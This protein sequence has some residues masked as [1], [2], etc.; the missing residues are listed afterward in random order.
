MLQSVTFQNHGFPSDGILFVFYL[1]DSG[2]ISRLILVIVYF[3][4]LQLSIELKIFSAESLKSQPIPC[5][6]PEL[7]RLLEELKPIGEM[8]TR[9]V[10]R[11]RVLVPR[12]P[13]V[14]EK[15][16]ENIR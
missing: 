15:E 16:S 7:N 13:E 2:H 1:Q 9:P 4:A 12:S 10:I 3:D 14:L 6:I 8:I 11:S 5:L